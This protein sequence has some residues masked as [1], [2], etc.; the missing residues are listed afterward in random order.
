M[1]DTNPELQAKLQELDHELEE[2]D[3]TQKGLVAV[4]SHIRPLLLLLSLSP[5]PSH[6]LRPRALTSSTV[7]RNGE[8]SYFRSIW[9]LPSRRNYRATCATRALPK[10]MVPA[11]VLHRSP[12]SLALANNSPNRHIL[13]SRAQNPTMRAQRGRQCI[14]RARQR[15]PPAL[16]STWHIRPVRWGAFK[17]SS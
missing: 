13:N 5:L 15:A 4:P 11:P 1:T 6:H 8:P 14:M 9:V 16:H 10:A 7:T 17:R 12:P 3:I 2:G